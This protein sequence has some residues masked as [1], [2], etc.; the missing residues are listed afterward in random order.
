MES[1]IFFEEANYAGAP[2]YGMNTT[3]GSARAVLHCGS[4]ELKQKVIP[5]VLAG[6]V[7]IALGLSEPD[8]GSDVAAAKT[9]AVRTA[10]SG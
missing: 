3:T 1:A 9:A 8:S 7:I 5:E 2:L 4:D 10:R 6:R